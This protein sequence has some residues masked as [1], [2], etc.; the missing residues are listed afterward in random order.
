MDFVLCYGQ[1]IDFFLPGDNLVTVSLFVQDIYVAH[2]S[3][4]PLTIE[5]HFA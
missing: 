4:G 5:R 3:V 1:M 2:P